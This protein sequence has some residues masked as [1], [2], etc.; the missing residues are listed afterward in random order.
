EHPRRGPVV[1]DEDRPRGAV[2]R[3]R[4]GCAEEA[5]ARHARV[6]RPV[7]RQT[8]RV[9]VGGVG[10]G[11]GGEGSKQRERSRCAGSYRPCGG[12]GSCPGRKAGDVTRIRGSGS[13]AGSRAP[14]TTA[15]QSSALSTRWPS[16]AR[17]V[18]LAVFSYSPVCGG[19]SYAAYTH[20][21]SVTGSV[22]VL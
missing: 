13:S 19:P 8:D 21:Y 5:L 4:D 11:P 6:G 20:Q 7:P 22:P 18:T 3:D 17:P 16:G 14:T 10:T 15:F 1:A 12:H 9:L 2:S